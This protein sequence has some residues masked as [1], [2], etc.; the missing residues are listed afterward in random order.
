MFSH[1]GDKPLS[2]DIPRIAPYATHQIMPAEGNEAPVVKIDYFTQTILNDAMPELG[3]VGSWNGVSLNKSGTDKAVELLRLKATSI[4]VQSPQGAEKI[5]ALATSIDQSRDSGGNSIMVLHGREQAIG[6]EQHHGWQARHAAALGDVLL[7]VGRSPELLKAKEFLNRVGYKADNAMA[8]LEAAAKTANGDWASAGLTRA[9][10]TRFLRKF[11][12]AVITVRGPEALHDLPRL[13]KELTL[14]EGESSDEPGG[15]SIE[16]VGAETPAEPGG[17]SHTK[18]T[19]LELGSDREGLSSGKDRPGE[20]SKHLVDPRQDSLFSLPDAIG[21][22]KDWTSDEP[23]AGDTQRAIQRQTRGELDRRLAIVSEQLE[24]QRRNFRLR[25]REDALK[26]IDAAEGVV[27]MSSIPAKDQA[28]AASFK[29]KFDELR[30]AIQAYKPNVLENF[31]ENYFPHLWERPARASSI[32]RQVVAGKRPFAGSGSF[33]K[34]RTIPTTADGIAMGLRPVSYNPVDLFLVKYHEM[35]KF[36]MAQKTIDMMEQGGTAKMVRVGQKAPD[37]W[38]RLDDRIGTKYAKNDEDQLFVAGNY[39]APPEAARVFNNSVS[40]GIAGRWR[41]YDALQAV[42][43]NMNAFQ[44]GI[45]AFHAT[46][47][48]VNSAISAAALGAQQLTQGKPL[49]ALSNLAQGLTVLPALVNS[50]RNGSKLMQ[51]YRTSDET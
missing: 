14:S 47:T 12:Q 50:V 8:A 9:E 21:R 13:S 23:D 28:L 4:A 17:A 1:G 39:Y 42:N 11:L 45:S 15:A 25:P 22:F 38:Q 30:E 2:Q 18:P 27:P 33:L 6:E 32:F 43:S 49:S 5:R 51:E 7:Q 16:R 29:Q 48:T 36:L 3:D 20:G 40:R 31:L 37:G 19:Q 35:N 10:G 44:L 26:F 46:T 34:Q 41:V 24:G